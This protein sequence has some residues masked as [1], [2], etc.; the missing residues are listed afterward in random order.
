MQT[1]GTL[2]LSVSENTEWIEDATVLV[3]VEFTQIKEI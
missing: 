2:T 3:V 1:E